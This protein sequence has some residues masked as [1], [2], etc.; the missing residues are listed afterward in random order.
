MQI[1]YITF[2]VFFSHLHVQKYMIYCDTFQKVSCQHT[3][4]SY[5]SSFPKQN[6]IIIQW[7][8]HYNNIR[9]KDTSWYMKFYC[10]RHTQLFLESQCTSSKDGSKVSGGEAQWHMY[11]VLWPCLRINKPCLLITTIAYF[12]LLSGYFDW[13]SE[14]S[15]V[16]I[17]F[18]KEKVER[19][20]SLTQGAYAE[21]R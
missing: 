16:H 4:V 19:C 5:S 3:A 13:L 10:S 9:H 18:V 14:Q 21:F 12:G 20:W 11:T 8:N 15:L 2:Q 1:S 7:N 17:C 6:V